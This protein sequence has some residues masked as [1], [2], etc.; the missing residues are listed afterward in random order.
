MSKK[1]LINNIFC[2]GLITLA[3]WGLMELLLNEYP[4]K[5][6]EP[7]VIKFVTYSAIV[8]HD[9]EIIRFKRIE[10][11]FKNHST[12]CAMRKYDCR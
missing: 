2:L 1:Q 7:T 5:Y 12:F 10:E 11:A 6:T 8:D 3:M 4:T 9:H